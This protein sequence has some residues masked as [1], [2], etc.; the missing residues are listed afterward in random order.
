MLCIF[1]RQK[2][3]G[4]FTDRYP[5]T[6]GE[7]SMVYE[8]FSDGVNGKILKLVVYRETNLYD[9]YNLGFGDKNEKTGR[10]DDR[11]ITNNGDNQK[12]L[13]TVASSLLEFTN[14]YPGAMVYATG[15]TKSRTQLYRMGISNNLEMIETNFEVFGQHKYGWELFR[16]GVEYDAFFVKR[17]S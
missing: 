7:T 8:F 15:T 2:T 1:K 12:V 5:L 6:V 4:L 13:V 10:I 11:V 14:K 3:F 16:K 9:F 17:K